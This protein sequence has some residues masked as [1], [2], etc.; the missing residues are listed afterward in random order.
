MNVASRMLLRLA[1]RTAAAL[2]VWI[3]KGLYRLGPGTRAV[4]SLLNRAAPAGPE[5]VE[6][7]GGLLRGTRMVL[8]LHTEKDYWLGTYEPAMQQAILE[9]LRAGQSAYDVGANIGY[10]TMMLAHVV[11]SYGLVVAFEPLAENFARLQE[12]LS[13]NKLGD[14][15]KPINAAVGDRKGEG[16][17]LVHSSRAMGKLS[18]SAGRSES[19]QRRI[20]VPIVALDEYVLDG[21]G[22]PP[23]LVKIDVEG[24]EHAV[25]SGMRQ[26]L[27]KYH[28]TILLELHGGL[29]ARDCLEILGGAGYLAHALEPRIRAI[30]PEDLP[31]RALVR[32][33]PVA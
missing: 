23:D 18:G 5:E 22:R 9:S 32:A 12:N 26:V 21:G 27:E 16:E 6:I 10:V 3:K 15:V 14:R 28:P 4:R 8:D 31:W 1:A 19:Y 25:L 29:A 17:F 33:E 30:R 7:A 24:G 13:L 20:R 2:P 11:S